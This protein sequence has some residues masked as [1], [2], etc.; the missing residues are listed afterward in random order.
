M[1]KKIIF[2][3]LFLFSLTGIQVASFNDWL[4]L[5][6]IIHIIWLTITSNEILESS[7]TEYKNY[8]IFNKFN[9][10]LV[11]LFIADILIIV[12][13]MSFGFRL[14]FASLYKPTFF[15]SAIFGIISIC[16]NYYIIINSLIKRIDSVTKRILLILSSLFYPIGV[17][18][19]TERTSKQKTFANNVYKK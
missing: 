7:I 5:S 3:V 9:K 12:L 11:Y 15:I 18:T 13:S 19:I 17:F 16:V 8:R 6:F 2:T 1:I 14:I 10:I 4:I